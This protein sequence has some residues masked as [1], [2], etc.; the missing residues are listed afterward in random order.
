MTKSWR[1]NEQMK[2]KMSDEV[3]SYVHAF[4][5]DIAPCLEPW[6]SR[7]SPR[8]FILTLLSA[9]PREICAAPAGHVHIS[10]AVVLILSHLGCPLKHL[11]QR[12]CFLCMSAKT[13]RQ[14]Q[15]RLHQRLIHYILEVFLCFIF[16]ALESYS[17]SN[18]KSVDCGT[19]HTLMQR[20]V[21]GKS[22]R[23]FG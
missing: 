11:T 3:R 13:Y 19:E 15:M 4:V 10:H 8:A 17:I 6:R 22:E 5:I 12:Q 20:D 21:G 16:P 23:H 18:S 1:Q 7:V 2:R 14:R 9:M